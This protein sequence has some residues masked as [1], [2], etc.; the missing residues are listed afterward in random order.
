LKILEGKLYFDI[1]LPDC[2]LRTEL[3]D[4]IAE[5]RMDVFPKIEIQLTLNSQGKEF[6]SI[7][8]YFRGQE[9]EFDI[10]IGTLNLTVYISSYQV[11]NY[12]SDAMLHKRIYIT[13]T[14]VFEED[15]ELELELIPF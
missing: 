15:E 11:G 6:N 14:L 2:K 4:S 3:L 7:L 5:V 10:E 8:Y 9:H 12:D 13:L 1:H